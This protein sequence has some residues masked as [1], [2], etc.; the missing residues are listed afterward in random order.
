MSTFTRMIEKTYEIKTGTSTVWVLTDTNVSMLTEEQYKNVTDK[1]T[2]QWFRRIGG[3]EYASKGC[4]RQGYLVTEL[5]SKNPD[6][7][8][9]KVRSFN[10]NV[11]SNGTM[12]EGY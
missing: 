7:T 8:I 1:K 5:I 10:F 3:S 11:N 4:T 2:Q 12:K 6:R 9:K